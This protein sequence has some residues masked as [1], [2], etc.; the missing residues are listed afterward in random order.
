[1]NV[2]KMIH[3]LWIVLATIALVALPGRSQDNASRMT[4]GV[5][6]KLVD[7]HPNLPNQLL[8]RNINNAGEIVGHIGDER[9]GTGFTRSRSGQYTEFLY[10]PPCGFFV[11]PC[12]YP[13]G[14]NDRGEIVGFSLSEIPERFSETR[15]FVQDLAGCTG[16]FRRPAKQH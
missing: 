11:N 5:A 16:K 14:I 3:S 12:S 2:N 6:I 8:P 15:R 1:M 13:M 10:P 9:D 4:Q 7:P